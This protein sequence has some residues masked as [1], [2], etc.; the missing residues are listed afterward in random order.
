MEIG[1]LNRSE[2]LS[3]CSRYMD[4]IIQPS[5]IYSIWILEYF[6]LFA[7]LTVTLS[8]ISSH[9]DF[10]KELVTF[11]L[12]VSLP[13]LH[14]N[15]TYTWNGP[16]PVYSSVIIKIYGQSIKQW[17]S[18]WQ[19]VRTKRWQKSTNRPIFH[20][21][22]ILKLNFNKRYVLHTHTQ[23]KKHILHYSQSKYFTCFYLRLQ[24]AK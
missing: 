17:L 9:L 20:Y 21:I 2:A 23:R 13:Q 16:G 1:S 24:L 19:S 8:G 11:L 5:G 4:H 15:D 18:L 14:L 7:I 6:F 10:Q 22:V 3:V 12:Y